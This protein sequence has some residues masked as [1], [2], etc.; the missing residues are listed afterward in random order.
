MNMIT[1]EEALD[2][3]N[4]NIVPSN[5]KETKSVLNALNQVLLEDVYSPINMPP[6]RQS[7]MDGYAVCIHDNLTYALID[8]VKAGD[9]HQPILK[10]GDAVRIFTGAAIPDTSNGVVIQEKVVLTL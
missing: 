7:A 6:F 3:V 5:Q 1:V 4:K 9:G 10:P 8:E 2:L